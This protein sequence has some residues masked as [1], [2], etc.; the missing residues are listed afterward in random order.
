MVTKCRKV[1]RSWKKAVGLLVCERRR[2]RNRISE[3]GM[4]LEIGDKGV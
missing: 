3:Y 4:V 1:L 2:I